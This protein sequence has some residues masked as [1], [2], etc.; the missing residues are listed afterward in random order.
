MN[1]KSA[2][3]LVAAAYILGFNGACDALSL[4]AKAA[5]EDLRIKLEN[6][7][8]EVDVAPEMVAYRPGDSLR[9]AL[10]RL[11]KT[12]HS[13]EKKIIEEKKNFSGPTV[14]TQVSF[15]DEGYKVGNLLAPKIEKLRK[16][17]QNNSIAP[18]E[19]VVLMDEDTVQLTEKTI[20]EEKQSLNNSETSEKEVKSEKVEKTEKLVRLE[21]KA[22]NSKIESL[23]KSILNT[24]EN[25]LPKRPGKSSQDKEFNADIRR[26]EFKMPENYR[27]IVR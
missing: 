6:K 21:N 16:L 11:R 7:Q 24:E 14:I 1:K 19:Q 4:E 18:T 13:D 9:A 22:S 8:T 20:T 23:K 10:R 25:S 3:T 17:R 12:I 2:V 5:I 15:L 27:I 26:Y